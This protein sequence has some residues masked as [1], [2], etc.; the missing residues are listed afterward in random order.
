MGGA[1]LSLMICCC[2]DI[3]YQAM[4]SRILY[5]FNHK[6]ELKSSKENLMY[7][8]WGDIHN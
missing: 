5:D 6:M 2:N 7:I 3:V 8:P 1:T 4:E